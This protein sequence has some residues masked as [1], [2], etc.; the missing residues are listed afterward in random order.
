MVLTGIEVHVTV[1][2]AALL[3]LREV[4]VYAVRFLSGDGCPVIRYEDIV[5]GRC[6]SFSLPF[7]P[8]CYFFR[9]IGDMDSF[10]ALAARM[11]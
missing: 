1:V 9:A 3:H 2:C 11:T 4:R 10:T 7:R 8:F 6:L 5:A